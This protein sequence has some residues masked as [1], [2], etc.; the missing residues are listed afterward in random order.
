MKKIIKSRQKFGLQPPP[1]DPKAWFLGAGNIP[2]EVLQ[3][4]GKWQKFLPDSELQNKRG[5]ETYDCTGFAILEATESYELRK[6]GVRKNY[7]DRFLGICAG[8]GKK[9]G[10]DPH[11]V[12]EVIRKYG[13]IPEEMLPFSDDLQ[14]YEEYYS[15]KG[16]DEK[17]CYEAGQK[18]LKENDFRHE[19]VYNPTQ[20]DDEKRNNLKTSLKFCPIPVSVYAWATDEQG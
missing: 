16:A 11:T 6:Y 10:N 15:F 18:W 20:P 17:A 14:N 12:C 19:W 7:S 2:W 3:A 9:Q 13:L 8:T 1:D 5:I 4:D